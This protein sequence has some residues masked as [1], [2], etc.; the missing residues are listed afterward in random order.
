MFFPKNYSGH[1]FLANIQV[2]LEELEAEL[3]ELRNR[4]TQQEVKIE[5]I[6]NL[7]LRQR[8]QDILDRMLQDQIEKENE[9][10]DLMELLKSID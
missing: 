9:K 3:T 8:F 5:N 1:Y 2:R 6:E 7:A 4:R 10:Y